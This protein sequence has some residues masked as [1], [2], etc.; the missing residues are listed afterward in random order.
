MVVQRTAAIHQLHDADVVI[1]PKTGHVRW[2]EMGRVDELIELGE[3]AARPTVERIKRLITP[4]VEPPLKW[5]Q[6]RRQQQPSSPEDKR[7]VSPLR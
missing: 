7:R 6:R 3:K 2:D 4:E 5:Y 1:S